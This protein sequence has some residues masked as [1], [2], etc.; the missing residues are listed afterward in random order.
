[1]IES[2]E[3]IIREQNN[4]NP[5]AVNNIL[6]CKSRRFKMRLEMRISWK[7]FCD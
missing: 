4:N 7:H 2:S 1:M 6:N 5:A 3:R